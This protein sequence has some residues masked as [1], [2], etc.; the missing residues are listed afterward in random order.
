MELTHTFTVPAG[1]DAVWEGLLDLERVGGCFPGATVT[2]VT[3]DGFSGTVKVKLGPIALVYAGS[4]TFLERDPEAHRA[5]IDAKGKDK[6]GNGTAGATVTMQLTSEG[7]QTRVDVATDLAIT[8]KPAQFGRGVMQDVSDKLLRQFVECIEDQFNAPQEESAAAAGASDVPAP[9][10]ADPDAWPAAAMSS[11][12]DPRGRPRARP[13][14]DAID[15]G[16]VAMPSA[17]KQWG[18]YAVAG[19]IGVLIGYAFGRDRN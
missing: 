3:D 16:A 11:G 17:V 2:D 7:D 6:R 5:V 9:A 1:I 19:L 4:G 14:D 15:L 13:V 8:G 12:P 18:P 10:G